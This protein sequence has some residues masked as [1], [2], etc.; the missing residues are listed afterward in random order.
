[1]Q[2]KNFGN[3]CFG[4]TSSKPLMKISLPL[5]PQLR[6]CSAQREILSRGSLGLIIL[7]RAS[8]REPASEADALALPIYNVTAWLNVSRAAS[9]AFLNPAPI[10]PVALFVRHVP[11][12][13]PVIRR[14]VLLEQFNTLQKTADEIPCTKTI[15]DWQQGLKCR[16]CLVPLSRPIG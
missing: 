6:V 15:G 10:R 11:D 9:T 2:D 12:A 7:L 3:S 5:I 16:L 1:M 14:R 4:S 8:R 13:G